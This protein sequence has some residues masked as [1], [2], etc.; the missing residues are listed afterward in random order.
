MKTT[1]IVS[2][3][4]TVSV[5]TVGCEPAPVVD[6][7]A[8]GLSTAQTVVSSCHGACGELAPSGDCWCDEICAEQGDCCSDYVNACEA[9][10][11]TLT[12]G[13]FAGFGCPKG[14]Y[15][16][17]GMG[18][19]CGFADQTGTCQYVPSFCTESF[20]PVCGCNG[21]NYANSCAAALDGIS[22]SFMGLCEDAFLP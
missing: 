6:T 13:G 8:L 11:P 7:E 19:A 21:L 22:P 15:C 10:E 3:L 9:P 14:Q 12:C 20:D 4:A 5:M 16:D 18:N 2:L 17:F 1:L